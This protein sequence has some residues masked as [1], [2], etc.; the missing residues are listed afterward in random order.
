MKIFLIQIEKLVQR[1]ENYFQRKLNTCS[2]N[3]AISLVS[4]AVKPQM[5]SNYTVWTLLHFLSHQDMSL[6]ALPPAREFDITCTVHLLS[7]ISTAGRVFMRGKLGT[8]KST[9]LAW[10]R[11]EPSPVVL[12]PPR[13]TPVIG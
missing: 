8:Y 10:S 6:A 12:S 3:H 9:S 1:L 5:Q 11:E 2:S 4:Q 13:K 7:S